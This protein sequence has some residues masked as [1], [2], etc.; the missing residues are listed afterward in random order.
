MFLVNLKKLEMLHWQV[1]MPQL[2]KL[3]NKKYINK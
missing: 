1:E 2:L 3:K